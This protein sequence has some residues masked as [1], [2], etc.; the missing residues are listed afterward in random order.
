M[1]SVVT[2]HLGVYPPLKASFHGGRPK[3]LK[4][5]TEHIIL[6]DV[7][8]GYPITPKSVSKHYWKTTNCKQ[9][10]QKQKGEDRKP[11]RNIQ[12]IHGKKKSSQDIDIDA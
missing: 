10:K 11:K 12:A 4:Y 2:K 5:T 3:L 7:E 9:Q 1:I 6:L 8:L